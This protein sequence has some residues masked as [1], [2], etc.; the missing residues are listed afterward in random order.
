M[1]IL[2]QLLVLRCAHRFVK[3]TR[4]LLAAFNKIGGYNGILEK[5][6]H[7]ATNYTLENQTFYECGMPREDSFHIFRDPL[8]A[9]IPWTGATLGLT[10]LALSVWCQDQVHVSISF[11]PRPEKT[12]LRGLRPRKTQTDLLSVCCSHMAYTGF[13]MTWLI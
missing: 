10:F 11:E 8:T 7:A 12:R 5:Y 9:D 3:T 4:V 1:V 13:L 6:K 2:K